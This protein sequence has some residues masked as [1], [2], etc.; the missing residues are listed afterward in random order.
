[1]FLVRLLVLI[2]IISASSTL[3]SVY[4]TICRVIYIRRLFNVPVKRV[5]VKLDFGNEVNNNDEDV[6][7]LDNEVPRPII[8]V[9]MANSEPEKKEKT[10]TVQM[11]N[12]NNT[13][14]PNPSQSKISPEYTSST[15][16]S[17][18]QTLKAGE[19]EKISADQWLV[20]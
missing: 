10:T 11:V 20:S 16:L 19:S 3:I 5:P 6:P 1:M 17:S 9:V 12:E 15:S 8:K 18:S 13:N 4:P 7:N 14:T 2:V